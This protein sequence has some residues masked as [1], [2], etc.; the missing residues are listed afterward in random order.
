MDRERKQDYQDRFRATIEEWETRL[1]ELGARAKRAEEGLRARLRSDE[2]RLR[3]KL[4]EAQARLSELRGASE[5]GW[6][7][8]KAGAE[9]IWVD[10]RAVWAKAEGPEPTEETGSEAGGAS[11]DI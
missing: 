3:E 11:P 1:E 7:E 2:S 4:E 9:K 8:V 6:E 5:E 10:V